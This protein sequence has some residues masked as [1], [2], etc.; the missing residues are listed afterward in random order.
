MNLALEAVLSVLWVLALL[1][2]VWAVYWAFRAHKG[3]EQP[4]TNDWYDLPEEDDEEGAS[5]LSP[6]DVLEM[7]TCGRSPPARVEA[8]RHKISIQD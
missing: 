5:S 4:V 7:V 8:P 6:E 1:F 3:A 2:L